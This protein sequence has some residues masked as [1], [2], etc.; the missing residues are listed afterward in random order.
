MKQSSSHQ[1]TITKNLKIMEQP[2][3]GI[4][5]SELRKSKGLTQEELVEQCN[6]S[7]RTIQRIEAGEVMPRSY[8]IKTILSALDYDLEKIQTEDSKVTKEFKKL[9]LLEIDDEKEASFLTK[10]LN[11][12]WISGI[13]YFILG[14]GEF[15]LDYYRHQEGE[16]IINE[17]A[18]ILLKI[19]LLIS[20]VLFTRGFVLTGKIF[21]NYLLRITAF[22]FIFIAV[23]FYGFDIISLYIVEINYPIVI[24]AEA[25]T[26]GIIGILFGISI[27]RLQGSLGTIA[28]VTAIFEIITYAFMTTILLSFVGLVFLTP[29]ILLEIILLFKVCEM[30]KAK[31]KTLAVE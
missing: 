9:F 23:V 31:E 20:I 25:M 1:E 21:K 30:I 13:V 22:M 17:I 14:F 24:G 3:L 2:A 19:V 18:Y 28:K 11:I 15:A 4:K 27:Y 6:I 29:T 26:Y 16:M 12:A 8:T 5:I 7:V 10:Q